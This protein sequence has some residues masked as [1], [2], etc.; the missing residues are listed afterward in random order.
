[1]AERTVLTVAHRLN[2]IKNSDLIYVL[3]KGEVVESGTFDDLLS[4]EGHFFN[5]QRGT[6]F[7][8]S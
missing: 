8:K 7:N 2:T 5:L 6:E 4:Q 3:E 1:M